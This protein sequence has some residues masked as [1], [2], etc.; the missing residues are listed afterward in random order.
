VERGDGNMAKKS[1]IYDVKVAWRGVAWR[2]GEG[3]RYSRIGGVR[4]VRA[5]GET[6]G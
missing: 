5:P 6:L 1:S 2:G 3:G 4:N